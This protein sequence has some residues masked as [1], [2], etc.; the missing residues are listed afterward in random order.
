M[1]LIRLDTTMTVRFHVRTHCAASLVPHHVRHS[2]TTTRQACKYRYSSLTNKS[3]VSSTQA[4]MSNL[5][6]IYFLF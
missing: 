6:I 2:T 3:D 4:H 5:V 1:K